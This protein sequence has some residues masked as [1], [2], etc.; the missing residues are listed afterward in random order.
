MIGNI[1]DKILD[2]YINNALVCDALLVFVIWILNSNYSIVTYTIAKKEENISILS[3]TIAASISLAGFILAA[4]TIIA[5]I[6]SNLANKTPQDARNPLE[7][8]FSPTNYRTIMKVFQGS[9]KELT[10]C[11]IVAYTTWIPIEN[12]SNI[13]LFKIL[14]SIIFIISISLTRSLMVL[15]KIV[16]MK[17]Y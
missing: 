12:I 1:R 2:L 8:F 9:I 5:A 13:L 3:D 15:Y 10:C 11:C 17:D 4:L 14:V 16:N 6:K 7:L